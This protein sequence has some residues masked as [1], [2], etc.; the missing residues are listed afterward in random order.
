[1]AGSILCLDIGSGTQDALYYLTD[2]EIENCP[3][4]VL[5]APARLVAA[6]I[7]G[8][9][10]ARRDIYLC[11]RNMGGGFAPAL[12]RH[13]KAGLKAA[14]APEAA[15]ALSDDPARVEDMGVGLAERCPRDHVPVHLADFDPGFWTGLL[16]QAG[17]AYPD[18]VLAAAQDHGYHPGASNRLGRFA[19]WRTFLEQGGRMDSLVYD[20]PPAAYTRLRT[21]QESTGGGPVAD[22]GAA[23]V[24]GALHDPDIEAR[25]RRTG[26]CL[27]NLGNS[28]VLGFLLYQGRVWSIYEHHTGMLPPE[29]L[30]ADLEAFRAGRLTNEEVFGSGGHGLAA[31]GG[32]EDGGLPAGAG[33]FETV[34]VLGPRRRM[35]AGHPVEFP[36]PGGDMMLCGA[37]G[38]LKGYGLGG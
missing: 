37:Y 9:T 38:L 29:R 34:C 18:L 8:L 3:K 14:C 19:L 6:R 31:V 5:P 25:S 15:L 33:G 28:H 27:V 10:A 21:L 35:L 30:W 36:A 1:M 20:Q 16:A 7:E 13:L 11:G 12:R 2:R 4:F 32:Q 23:A 17:L 24:L 22:T 26:V